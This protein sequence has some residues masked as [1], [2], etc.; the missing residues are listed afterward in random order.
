MKDLFEH[1]EEM[2]NHIAAIVNRF[3]KKELSYDA[4]EQLVCELEQEGYTCEYGLDAC[5]FNLKKV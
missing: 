2:P 5:P 4:C 3:L 1:Y